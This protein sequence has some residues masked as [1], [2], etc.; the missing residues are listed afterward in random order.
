M[1]SGT[2]LNKTDLGAELRMKACV[3]ESILFPFIV[4]YSSL[5]RSPEKPQGNQVLTGERGGGGGFYSPVA[6]SDFVKSAP[7]CNIR[8]ICL[9]VWIAGNGQI[10]SS[11]ALH[12]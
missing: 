6:G 5:K 3:K 12:H 1:I 7:F 2:L 10:S 8:D 4:R 9:S 11:K